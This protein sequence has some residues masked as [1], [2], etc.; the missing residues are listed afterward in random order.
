MVRFFCDKAVL[1]LTL[2]VKSYD[3][4]DAS[5]GRDLGLVEVPAGAGL[6]PF[7]PADGQGKHRVAFYLSSGTSSQGLKNFD[8]CWFP[9][10]G[11]D[12]SLGDQNPSKKMGTLRKWH[13]PGEKA[14]GG[15]NAGQDT[16]SVWRQKWDVIATSDPCIPEGYITDSG[17][18]K[19]DNGNI[20]DLTEPEGLDLYKRIRRSSW[21][22][23]FSFYWQLEVS[24][25]CG[26]PTIPEDMRETV[27]PN[28][29][30]MTFDPSFDQIPYLVRRW[31]WNEQQQK[32]VKRGKGKKNDLHCPFPTVYGNAQDKSRCSSIQGTQIRRP[33][34]IG[35]GMRTQQFVF[36]FYREC[37]SENQWIESHGGLTIKSSFDFDA[38]QPQV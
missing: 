18:L 1:P 33:E 30:G 32:F 3:G 15:R 6:T 10:G 23:K 20:V 21:A 37:L 4:K 34:G 13:T 35:H 5:W 22:D 36:Q 27:F 16:R 26:V 12:V 7:W 31:K 19:D 8:K 2:G 17:P 11:V 14:C 29:F 24:V 38:L 9:M 28:Y 25:A